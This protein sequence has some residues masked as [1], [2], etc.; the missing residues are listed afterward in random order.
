M[1]L[2]MEKITKSE[3]EIALSSI[4]QLKKLEAILLK[5]DTFSIQISLN[6]EP[7]TIP[8]KAFS[9][10][11]GILETMS[12]G[13]SV[14]VLDN[15]QMLTTQEAAD[16]LNVSRPYIVKLLEGGDIPFQKVGT[17]RR[18]L[19]KDVMAYDAQFREQQLKNMA[20]LSQQAQE[21]NLGYE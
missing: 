1:I 8:K 7:L 2:V 10:L 16:I 13:Q 18:L 4:E 3:Q 20:L 21:L 19:L 9:L 5:E 11:K 14:T 17:H 6:N 15:E 12:K